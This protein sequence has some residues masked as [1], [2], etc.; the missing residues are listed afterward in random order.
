M[1]YL[2]TQKGKEAIK[3]AEFQHNIIETAVCI[4]IL[5]MDRSGLS[6]ITL[7]LLFIKI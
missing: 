2:K 4:K 5:T 1:L 3:A 7:G 6:P